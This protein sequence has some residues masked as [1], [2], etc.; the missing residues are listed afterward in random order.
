MSEGVTRSVHAGLRNMIWLVK[1]IFKI[2]FGW[3][4]WLIRIELKTA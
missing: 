2:D 3:V 1:S 4:K